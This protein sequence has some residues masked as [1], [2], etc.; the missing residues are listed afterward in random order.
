[1]TNVVVEL[2]V[3]ENTCKK[4]RK[5]FMLIC[6]SVWMCV[7]VCLCVCVCVY[8]CVCVCVCVLSACYLRVSILCN[9]ASAYLIICVRS[10]PSLLVVCLYVC[11]SVYLCV[12]LYVCLC[13]AYFSTNLPAFLPGTDNAWI[14]WKLYMPQAISRASVR[15]FTASA[16]KSTIVN[17]LNNYKTNRKIY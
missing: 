17:C 11:I 9:F 1:M 12:R 10:A 4:F 15:M 6:V 2:S 16:R 7:C 14:K 5:W 13:A 8:V 3:V